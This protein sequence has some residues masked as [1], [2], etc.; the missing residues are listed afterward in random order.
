MRNPLTGW[1]L[2]LFLA[3]NLL[4]QNRPDFDTKITHPGFQKLYV[5]TD[6]EIYFLGDTIWLS[7]YLLNGKT[8][9]PVSNDQN[10]YVDLIDSS[11]AI[12]KSGIFPVYKGF[13]EGNIPIVDSL[14]TGNII[15]RAYTNYLRNFGDD[16]FFYKSLAIER[17]KNSFEIDSRTFTTANEGVEPVVR[18]FPE[19]GMLLEHTPNVIG[20]KITG[21]NGES[22]HTNGVVLNKD[23]K[24]VAHFVTNYKGL[25]R[26]DFYPNSGEEYTVVLNAFPKVKVQF[27]E[28]EKEGIK[29]QLYNNS[30]DL[31]HVGILSNSKNYYRQKYTLACMNR[32]EVIFYKK[33]RPTQNDFSVKIEKNK[34][35]A[36]INR[37]LLLNEDLN[38]VSERLYFNNNIE[39]NTINIELSDSVFSNRSLADFHLVPDKKF[40]ADSARLSIAV[41]DENS[42]NAFGESQTLLSQLYLDAEL[43]GRIESPANYF[44]DDAEISA[45]QKLDLL[46]LT[47]GWSNYIWNKIADL[48]EEE[49]VYPVT[50][51][52]TIGGYVTNL[53]NKKRVAESEVILMVQ[54]DS[55][56][57]S[58]ETSDAEGRFVFQ[59]INLADS[60]AV[61]LQARKSSESENTRVTIEPLKT[62]SAAF[63]P[64][65]FKQYSERNKIPLE[66]YRQ[67]YYASLAEK[68]FEPEKD[69]ILIDEVKVSANAPE[70]EEVKFSQ[71]YSEPDIMIKPTDADFM[72]NTLKDFLFE[73]APAFFGNNMP[74]SLLGGSARNNYI[75]YL[76]GILWTNPHN[77]PLPPISVSSIDRVDII[78]THNPTGVALLG[79]RGSAGG[80]FIYTKRGAPDEVREKYLKGVIKQKIKGF[81]KYREFY[82]P[83]YNA[84][85][86]NSERPDHRTTLYW[87]PSVKINN[88]EANISFFTSDDNARYKVLVEGIT[89][90]GTVC[91]GEI[92]FE[93]TP[94]ADMSE[95][96]RD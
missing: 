2:F 8:H 71:I 79:S 65:K 41:V 23:N 68:A 67:N 69:V 58:W 42:L 29:L 96:L 45:E 59:H 33:V 52:F 93:V 74:M 92:S 94:D 27:W 34:F 47:H 9:A 85:N 84:E 19:G 77:P 4:A 10:L 32:G 39:T 5:Q 88:G 63:N 87:N 89:S 60:A 15:F 36:G 1:F 14:L 75:V 21:K 40:L 43:I 80:V 13:G 11:G 86:I 18:F 81:S 53:W 83:T 26:F 66:L 12:L 3:Q 38:P 78:D 25:G 50:A 46:M 54:N 22:I 64:N 72:A 56:F 17:T 49:F 82:S 57:S 30:E 62:I 61:T 44:N 35:G 95:S 31:L 55:L 91:F 90:A 51:G 24:T 70:Q 7:A 73:K 28:A 76:D 6:R 48:D 16:C 37:L 20:V